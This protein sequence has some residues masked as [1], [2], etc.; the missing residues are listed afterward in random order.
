[1][2]TKFNG[3]WGG[4]FGAIFVGGLLSIIPFVGFAMSYC[5]V[6]KYM[7]GNTVIGGKQLEFTGV[8]KGVWVP[9]FVTGLLAWI[10]ALAPLRLER[11][12]LA[13]TAVKG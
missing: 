10:P 11:L 4:V 8:W 3:T 7:V 12:K 13:N 6:M 2:E 5:Y 1:M 9:L